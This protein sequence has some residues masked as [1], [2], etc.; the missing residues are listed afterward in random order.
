MQRNGHVT[1]VTDVGVGK[2]ENSSMKN[3]AIVYVHNRH[4]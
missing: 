1:V 4:F 2:S 3:A